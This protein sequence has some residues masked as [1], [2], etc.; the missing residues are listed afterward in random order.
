M[1]PALLAAGCW[2]LWGVF[3]LAAWGEA[4]QPAEAT[5]WRTAYLVA[6]IRQYSTRSIVATMLRVVAFVQSVD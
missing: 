6:G 5:F 2:V 4:Q 3:T 1:L